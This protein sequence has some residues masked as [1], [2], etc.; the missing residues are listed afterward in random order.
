[1]PL[2]DFKCKQCGKVKEAIVKCD[3]AS[4]ACVCGGETEKLITVDHFN[5]YFTNG[6]GTYN[7]G[8]FQKSKLFGK[9]V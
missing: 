6:G 1:M 5:F 9:D 3:A 2:Y 8:T 7:G 4:P